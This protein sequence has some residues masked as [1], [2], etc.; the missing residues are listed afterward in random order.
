PPR[1][2]APGQG[3]IRAESLDPPGGSRALVRTLAS[4]ISRGTESL[5]F[6]GR[7]PASEQAR[8]RCPF[9]AG[10]FP[11]PVKY[12]Y[13][14][15]GVVESGPAALVGRRVFALHPHQD[16]F[17]VPADAL[18]PVPDEVPTTRAVLAANMETALNIAWDAAALPGERV[19]VIG[20][21]VVGLLAASLLSRIPA[22]SL[23]LVDADPGKADAAR[24]LGLP[25]ALPE[26]APAG[27]ELIVHA[28]GAPAALA[29]ALGLAAFEGRIVEASWFGDRG[30]T[31]PL[32]EA[33]HSRR[34]RL[35]SSQVGAVA[36]PMRGRRSHA[37]RLALALALL[38]DP[39]YDA[40]L[41]GPS[42]FDDLPRTMARLA[43]SPGVLC[44]VVSYTRSP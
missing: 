23:T 34:L 36:A 27:A 4:G 37:E 3:E 9:Q 13:S 1:R 19:L 14:A 15:V 16:R 44:H 10:S 25:F 20:A 12:G 6:A 29:R 39:A 7:V 38:A 5:V 40:L 21:G 24:A 18:T 8:M 17:V 11:F 26:T 35:I 2:R 32:G 22:V 28:S 43:Q 33:F 42:R 31:L 30:V 41:D